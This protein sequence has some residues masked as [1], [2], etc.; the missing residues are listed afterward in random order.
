MFIINNDKNNLKLKK[1]ELHKE[2]NLILLSKQEIDDDVNK[3]GHCTLIKKEFLFYYLQKLFK[4][5][6]ESFYDHWGEEKK[7]FL[8]KLICEKLEKEKNDVYLF[9]KKLFTNRILR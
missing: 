6:L 2:E 8:D 5:A 3:G 4:Y 1:S 9:L 7:I